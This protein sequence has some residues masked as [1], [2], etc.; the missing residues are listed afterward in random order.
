VLVLVLAYQLALALLK[1]VQGMSIVDARLRDQ[2]LRAAKTVCLNIAEGVGRVSDADKKRV[3]AI[4]RGECCETA[5]A[6]DVARAAGDCDSAHGQAA[7]DTAGRVYALLTGLR[8]RYDFETIGPKPSHPIEH[9]NDIVSTDEN[10]LRHEIDVRH[11]VEH[12]DELG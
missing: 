4:A 10:E 1:Q 11:D 7:R 9:G 12:E 8:R 6:I 2:I 3:Y 5:A